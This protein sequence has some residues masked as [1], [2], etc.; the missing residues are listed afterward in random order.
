[1]STKPIH[2]IGQDAASMRRICERIHARRQAEANILPALEPAAG[3]DIDGRML[4]MMMSLSG[5]CGRWL[6]IVAIIIN[7][8]A[9]LIWVAHR[10]FTH[11]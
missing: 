2:M 9:V 3:K 1:M 11:S 6:W 7:F 10:F 4:D 8:A 5:W